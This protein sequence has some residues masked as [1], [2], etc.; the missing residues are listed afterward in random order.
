[1]HI[2]SDGQSIFQ[3]AGSH[4]KAKLLE[5]F[6]YQWPFRAGIYGLNEENYFEVHPIH[7]PSEVWFPATIK[8]QRDDGL[9]EVI[10]LEPDARGGMSEVKYP[11]VEKSQ[12][13]D[14][15]THKPLPVPE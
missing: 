1:V 6:V 15:A 11:A 7:L 8:R 13:R 10:A 4:A 9:F 2:E 14:A 3:G 5:D 12:L